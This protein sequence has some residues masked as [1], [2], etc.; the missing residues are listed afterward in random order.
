VR[1]L[2]CKYDLSNLAEH[3]CP[4]CGRVFDPADSSTFLQLGC[5]EP[6]LVHFLASFAVFYL[7]W[8]AAI[9]IVRIPSP[10]PTQ[11]SFA[12]TGALPYTFVTFPWGVVLMWLYWYVRSRLMSRD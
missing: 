1:C 12:L 3:R 7:L 10:E 9:F 11:L 8:I 5:F 4:E 6:R 2:S